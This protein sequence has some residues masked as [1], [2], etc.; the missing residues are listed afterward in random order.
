MTVINTLRER[1]ESY[2]EEADKKLLKKV[3]VVL[4]INGR[5]FKKITSLLV[6]PF[7][8]EFMELMCATMIKLSHEI[9]GTTFSYTFN[10]EIVIVSRNDKN[11][12]TGAW[13]D[14]R[15]QKM[16]SAASSIATLEFNRM[17]GINKV[18]L[19]GDPVFTTKAFVVPNITEAINLL[20]SKQQQAFHAA[21]HLAC[22]YELLKK[23]HDPDT[24]RQ[25][26]AE[27]SASGKIEIL[28][29]ECNIDFNNYPLPFKRGVAAYRV[30]K[31]V[32]TADGEE[33]KNK[34][35]VDMEL[36]LFVKE[37]NFLGTIF[38]TGHDIIRAK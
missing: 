10:D 30:P 23:K 26:L 4:I 19:F 5:S 37:H 38:N 6:K 14:N 12:E 36:P 34:L 29:E 3:P 25:T 31:V 28:F 15:I 24:V 18:Q 9:D 7:S 8:T 33:L 21:L 20:I 32:Q 2:E 13:Y 27:K 1:I 16:V 11:L 17:A 35:I 22:F